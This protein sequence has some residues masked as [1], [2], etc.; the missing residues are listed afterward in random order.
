MTTDLSKSQLV[1]IL[2]VLDS[3]RRS[4]ANKDAALKAIGR[5]AERL[6]LNTEAVLAAAAGLAR[7]PSR[8]RGLACLD[9]VRRA[10]FDR[11]PC[12]A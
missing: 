10:W 2:S 9:A 11:R 4:P 1:T 8:R 12:V 3:K 7:R 5:S 6:E